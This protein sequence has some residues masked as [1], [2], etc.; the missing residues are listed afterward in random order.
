MEVRSSNREKRRRAIRR[1][2]LLGGKIGDFDEASSKLI[3][4]P[5]ISSLPFGKLN[6]VIPDRSPIQFLSFPNSQNRLPPKVEYH[7]C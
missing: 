6:S 1:K 3:L 4:Q 5:K 2:A 7:K